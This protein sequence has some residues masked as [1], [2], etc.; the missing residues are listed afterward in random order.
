LREKYILPL[1]VPDEGCPF[2]CIYCNQKEITGSVGFSY[3][4]EITGYIEKYLSYFKD[5]SKSVMLCFFGGSFTG[6]E[7][8]K[9]T[10]Y[11]ETAY[12]YVKNGQISEIGL[13]T[14]PDYIDDQ[15]IT[16]LQQYK[17]TTIEIGAQSL[18]DDILANA[19][20]GHGYK[21]IKNAV[22]TIHKHGLR[23]GIQLLPGL[24]GETDE[25]ITETTNKTVMLSPEFTRIYPVLV[26]KNTK[27]EEMY[28]SGTYTPLTLEKAVDYS[29]Y[30]LRE[31]VSNS[32]CVVR[33]GLHNEFEDAS[34]K[35]VAAGPFH[36]SFGE[37]VLSRYIFRNIIAEIIKY[38]K[39][40]SIDVFVGKG[41]TSAAVGHKRVNIIALKEMTGINDI[42]IIETDNGRF[43]TKVKVNKGETDIVSK[44]S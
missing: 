5:K 8:S 20:R 17:V 34:D 21:D 32:I 16:S 4:G 41:M 9:Q 15:I 19:C 25:T 33:I 10:L 24:P 28:R 22:G 39:I 3:K 36:N 35:I 27:L 6:I 40:N 13:S 26:L 14:R 38:D 18:N 43:F 44:K 11:L 30:M 2:R 29:E 23:C 42:K 31:F 12:E 1:F 7:K 37:L